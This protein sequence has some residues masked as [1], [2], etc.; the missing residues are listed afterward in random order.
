[1]KCLWYYENELEHIEAFLNIDLEKGSKEFL[2]NSKRGISSQ[3][4]TTIGYRYI[5]QC[6]ILAGVSTSGCCD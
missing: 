1:M 3:V 2:S 5:I 6:S 4:V